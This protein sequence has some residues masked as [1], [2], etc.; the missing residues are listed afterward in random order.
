M[1]VRLFRFVLVVLLLA[2]VALLSAITTMHFA[3]HGA[4][5]TIPDF[6]TTTTAETLHRAAA[7]GLNISIDNRFYSAEL[8]AGRILSQSPA[9]GT[10]VRREWHVR[11]TESLGPQKVAIPNV[12][13]QPERMA[14]IEIRRLGLDLGSIAHLP[15]A[16]TAPDT[17]LAQNPP[18]DAAGV[19]RPSV[20]LLISDP[21]LATGAAYVMPDFTGQ[22]YTAAA[23]AISHAGLKLAPTQER[24][25]S[26]PAVP[27]AGSTQPVEAPIPIGSVLAQSPAAGHRIDAATPIELTVAR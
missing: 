27:A 6:R 4:E 16:A 10:I 13:G 7:L 15:D 1:M 17:V 12:I 20:S 9:P 11:V 24:M 8:P 21:A 3:I 19:E 26:I 2:I 23:L 25:V 22:P 18:P 14:T 5:V